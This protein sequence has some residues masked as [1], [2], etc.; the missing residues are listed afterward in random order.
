[1]S[2]PTVTEAA[3]NP[4]E[5]LAGQALDVTPTEP[6]PMAAPVVNALGRTFEKPRRG[7][8]KNSPDKK[9]KLAERVKVM[10]EWRV[11]GFTWPE[12][13]RR[14]EYRDEASAR[15]AVR[16]F[17]KNIPSEAAADLRAIENTRY[18][19]VQE[20]LWPGVLIGDLDAIDR[21]LRLSRERR[22]MNG[23]DLAPKFMLQG[24][25]DGAF[26]SDPI[27]ERGARFRERFKNLPVEAKQ[28]IYRTLARYLGPE[29]GDGAG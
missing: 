4:L 29:E 27:D 10:I 26:E 14:A 3:W 2:A 6:V 19:K 22:T 21:F 11:Q 25:T 18:D 24:P 5:P 1:M 13:A 9:V 20:V 8:S 15:R 16:N 12:I 23:I 17:W 7:G 28:E